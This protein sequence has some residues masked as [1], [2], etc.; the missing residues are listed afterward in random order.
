MR[1][2]GT[3]EVLDVGCPTNPFGTGYCVQNSPEG[4]E[5]I[6]LPQVEDPNDLLTPENLVRQAGVPEAV[7]VIATLGTFGRTWYPRSSYAGVPPCEVDRVRVQ[8]R[9]G[10]DAL[11]PEKDAD[12]I[13]MLREFEPPILSPLFFQSASPCLALPHLAGDEV[14]TL[15]NL[16]ASGFLSFNLPGRGPLIAFESVDGRRLIPVVL[17]TMVLDV[18]A[19][20]LEMTFRGNVPLATPEAAE[21]FSKGALV[22]KDVDLSEMGRAGVG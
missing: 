1:L 16:S 18:E 19:G 2:P 6:R 20:R 22:V 14:I 12:A 21:A 7:P 4:L 15:Q 10:A 13:A 8:V 17:D 9:S 11:D 3:D 5:G